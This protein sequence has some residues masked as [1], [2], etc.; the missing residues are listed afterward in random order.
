MRLHTL[1]QNV[2]PQLEND[3]IAAATHLGFAAVGFAQVAPSESGDVFQQWLDDGLA[4]DMEYLHRHAPLRR[5]PHHVAPGAVSI[6]AV[7]ARYPVNP[8]PGIGFC[9]LA[10]TRDYHD[11]LRIKLRLLI[12]T[13]HRHAP[14][15]TARICVDS[16][17][18]PER[19]WALRAGLGW[20]G[21]QSQLIIPAAG[22][23]CVLGFLLVD[24]K[25]TPSIPV[26]DQCADCHCCVKSCPAQAIQPHRQVDARRCFSYLTIEH[27]GAFAPGL[28]VAP[29]ETLF[30]CD[31]CTAV[32]P[33]NQ[34]ATAPVMPELVARINPPEP[35]DIM[36]M[37][38][39][40]F[41]TRFRS[42]TVKR[43]G[44]ERVR[45]NAAAAIQA[46]SA[47]PLS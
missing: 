35:D 14:H 31:I 23:C 24:I 41:A 16:A 21:R 1:L 7:A 9:M 42:T 12:A 33:W 37:T 32:C 8:S 2:M 20:Q 28:Q 4:A 18:L 39:D 11:L 40:A 43:S 25:L 29:G 45:R 30:G 6:I 44:I 38:A 36:C 10:R 13:I 19:E 15:T 17:P 3:I 27:K 47:A 5:H 26:G 34:T 22:A 46:R